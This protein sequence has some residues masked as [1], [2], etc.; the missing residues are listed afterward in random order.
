M[1]QGSEIIMNSFTYV[2]LSWM[3]KWQHLY[4]RHLFYCWVSFITKW[5]NSSLH[6]F[7]L[8]PSSNL[9]GLNNSI[10]LAL[11]IQAGNSK[12]ALVDVETP[13]YF[14]YICMLNI[15]INKKWKDPCLWKL[16]KTWVFLNV[17]KKVFSQRSC[18]IQVLHL[19]VM[20]GGIV[21]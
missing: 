7:Y 18:S 15:W 20:L 8:H 1:V 5:C 19:Q 16:T 21:S 4:F 10:L 13:K 11:R 12:D 9:T 14:S 17:T 2:S 6:C 3:C